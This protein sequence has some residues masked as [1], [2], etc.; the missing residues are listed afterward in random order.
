MSTFQIGD[1]VIGNN[2]WLLGLLGVGSTVGVITHVGPYSSVIYLFM[3]NEDITLLNE[4]IDKIVMK[5]NE[6]EFKVGDLVELKPR[7]R[8]I[9][10]I[11]GVGTIIKQTI[12]KTSDHDRKWTNHAV[13][14]FL[15]YFP[16]VDYEYTI[17]RSC[18]RIFS[19][20]KND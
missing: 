8:D 4:Y 10:N 15:V 1:I 19:P 7:V 2:T 3:R 5:N 12:I 17:P 18:L 14:A 13:D 16:E 9:I 6:N 11:N 20:P